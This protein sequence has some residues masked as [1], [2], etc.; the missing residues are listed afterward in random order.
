MNNFVNCSCGKLVRHLLLLSLLK[1]GVVLERLK[2]GISVFDHVNNIYFTFVFTSTKE[3]STI[4][5]VIY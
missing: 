3:K 1:N 5:H 4:A 2:S